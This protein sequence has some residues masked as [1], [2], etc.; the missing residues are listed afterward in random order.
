MSV[1]TSHETHYVSAT[2]TSQLM[3]FSETIVVYCE[4]HMKHTDTLCGQN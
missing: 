3:L 4:S 2:E 1:R